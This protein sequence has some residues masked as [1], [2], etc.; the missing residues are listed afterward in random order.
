MRTTTPT[1]SQGNGKATAREV[2][3][4]SVQARKLAAV[5]LEVL[6]GLRSVPNAAAACELSL[7][8]YYVC[9]LR[10]LQGLLAACEPPP[11]GRQPTALGEITALKRRCEQLQQQVVRQ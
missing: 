5:I 1:R 8:R 9:E 3:G 2:Q 11:R 7:P 10:A 6:A 4:H